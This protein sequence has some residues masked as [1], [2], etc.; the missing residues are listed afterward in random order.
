[1]TR[2][3]RHGWKGVHAPARVDHVQIAAADRSGESSHENL[4]VFDLRY[5]D[6]R[7]TNHAALGRYCSTHFPVR[8]GHLR[9]SR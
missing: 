9:V 3:T 8:D 2:V 5:C 4:A 6:F 7:A 1:M